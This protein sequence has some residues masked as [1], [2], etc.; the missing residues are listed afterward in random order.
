MMAGMRTTTDPGAKAGA[1]P[2]F[3]TTSYEVC[4]T[5]APAVDG[6]PVCE[7]CGWLLDEH[8]DGHAVAEVRAL[9]GAMRVQAQPKRLAS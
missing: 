8:D 3:V 9:A 1:E 7:A 4:A 2:D 6:S 5:F